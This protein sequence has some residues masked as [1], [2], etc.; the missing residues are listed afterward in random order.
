MDYRLRINEKTANKLETQSNV[1]ARGFKKWRCGFHSGCRRPARETC[2]S[3]HPKEFKLA[4]HFLYQQL[5]MF[6]ELNI[7]S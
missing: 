7:F 5:F 6:A 3:K 4:L 1:N 2:K